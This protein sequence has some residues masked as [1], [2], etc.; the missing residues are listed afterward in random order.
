MEQVLDFLTD[1]LKKFSPYIIGGAIGSIIHRLRTE[2]TTGTFL[3]SVVV[4]IFLSICVGLV[5]KEQFHIENENLIFVFCGMSGTFSKV[6]LDE[7]EQ[8][9]K[10]GSVYVKTKLGI[11]KSDDTTAN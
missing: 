2:M 11:N 8:I 9:L 1:L 5:C 6:I 10:L 7:I 3:K 4:S